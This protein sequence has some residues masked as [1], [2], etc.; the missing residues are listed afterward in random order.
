MCGHHLTQDVI[1]YAIGT[2]RQHI[3][4]WI[5]K[6]CLSMFDLLRCRDIGDEIV[7]EMLSSI[8]KQLQRMSKPHHDLLK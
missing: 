5:I 2:V 1:Y 3:S 6:D 7:E 8:A 4:F